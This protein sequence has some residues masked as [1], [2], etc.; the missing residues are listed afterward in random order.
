MAAER[1][2]ST[3]E[4]GYYGAE[5]EDEEEEDA[6]EAEISGSSDEKAAS[7]GFTVTEINTYIKNIIECSPQL[8]SVSVWG[9][10]SNLRPNKSGHIYFTLKDGGSVIKAVMWKG[11][12]QRLSFDPKDGMKVAVHAALEM[13]VPFGYHQLICDSMHRL[14]V[15]ELYEAFEALKKKLEAEGLFRPQLKKKLPRFPKKIGIVT[16]PTG[17][18]IRDMMNVMRRRSPNTELLIYPAAVQG[19]D[20]PGQISGGIRY[21]DSRPD[22][23][24][25]I[26][27]RGGGSIEDLWC[28][29]DEGLARVIAGCGTPIISA[30]GHEIDF[31][32]SDF[33]ADVRAPTPSAAA[34]IAVPD[35]AAMRESLRSFRK[36]L[37]ES[38]GKAVMRRRLSL[39]NYASRRVFSQ[40]MSMVS[41]R[42]QLLDR[43]RERLDAAS[44]ALMNGYRAKLDSAAG[45]LDALSPLKI[46]ARGYGLVTKDG[47]AVKSASGISPGDEISVRMSDGRIEAVA[48][49]IIMNEQ[50]AMNGEKDA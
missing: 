31:T 8:A 50:S 44:S 17:A 28:F 41:D 42:I 46:L 47:S 20:A 38:V 11:A 45:R 1:D 5:Y 34:E 23:D 16:S 25:I 43:G 30:V 32:I 19:G 48:S 24:L 9:E 6:A 15:G 21:F 39:E 14:G 12:A 33:A 22:V 36:R 4:R 7:H 10:I 2:I 3:G 35:S 13:Y 40:P 37:D 29:N 49:E 27:G 18:A 26:I